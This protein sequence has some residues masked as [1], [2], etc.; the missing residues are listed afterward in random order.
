MLV[1]GFRFHSTQK[2]KLC[3]F[4]RFSFEGKTICYHLC[5]L[6]PPY[7]ITFTA[8]ALWNRRNASKYTESKF[9][10]VNFNVLPDEVR[11]N[12]SLVPRAVQPDIVHFQVHVTHLGILFE[13]ST[14]R[15]RTQIELITH[16]TNDSVIH[17]TTKKKT[18]ISKRTSSRSTA[19]FNLAQSSCLSCSS[20]RIAF[21]RKASCWFAPEWLLPE[22]KENKDWDLHFDWS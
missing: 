6:I 17:W 10:A 12:R 9:L 18:Q 19:S 22:L 14:D 21:N 15:K 16:K 2:K 8:L 7:F 1:L 5:E 4:I 20:V 13:R 3:P 11:L